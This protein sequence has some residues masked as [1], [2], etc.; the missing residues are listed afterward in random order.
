MSETRFTLIT[1]DQVYN[2]LVENPSEDKKKLSEFILENKS[3]GNS[4]IDLLADKLRVYGKRDAA[5]YAKM[6]DANTRHFDGAIRCLTGLSA[7]GWINEYLRLV[8]CDLV[9]HT[10]FT[11][12]TIGRILGFSGSSFSQFF[13][14]YQKMQ[15]WEYRSLKR[16]GRKIGFFYD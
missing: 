1:P 14:T 13:R 5:S 4:Y 12:K 3:S 7:H 10:N 8:A 9:E 2:G 15:P 16:H 11:F 6:F